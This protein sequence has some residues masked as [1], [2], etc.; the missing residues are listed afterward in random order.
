MGVDA[1]I[2]ESRRIL[3][4]APVGAANDISNHAVWRHFDKKMVNGELFLRR[5]VS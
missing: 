4:P 2:L 5:F 1:L 3:H